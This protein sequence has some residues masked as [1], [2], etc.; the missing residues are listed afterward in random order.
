[1]SATDWRAV[2]LNLLV[3]NPHAELDY[4]EGELLAP[5]MEVLRESEAIAEARYQEA[6]VHLATMRE[7]QFRKLVVQMKPVWDE[8]R[9][10]Y[11]REPV[12]VN[13]E[14]ARMMRE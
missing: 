6:R 14:V 9:R 5:F 8:T 1:M 3:R 13:K 7:E 10:K 2:L 11:G 12:D 4:P